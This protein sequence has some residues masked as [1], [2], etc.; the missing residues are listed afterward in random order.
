MKKKHEQSIINIFKSLFEKKCREYGYKHVSTSLDGQDELL[1]ADYIFS[2]T[3]KFILV[4]FKYTDKEINSEKKKPLR[5]K[6]CER[7]RDNIKEDCDKFIKEGCDK[8]S[9]HLNCHFISFRKANHLYINNYVGRVCNPVFNIK[10]VG[11]NKDILVPEFINCLL[12]NGSHGLNFEQFEMY[13]KWLLCIARDD[14]GTI[15]LIVYDDDST[16]YMVECNN[17]NDLY[18]FI[19]KLKGNKPNTPAPDEPA[20][21]E[22]APDEPINKNTRK[23]RRLKR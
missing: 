1:G 3:T 13:V 21:D 2:E 11:S 18:E 9:L 10:V 6:L 17:L 16:N 12:K 23:N 22:P 14:D 4:E 20:P 8:L 15:E 5:K 19:L 7:L